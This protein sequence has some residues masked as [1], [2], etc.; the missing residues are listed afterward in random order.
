G[1]LIIALGLMVDDAIII[2]EM[3]ARK[4]EEGYDRFRASTFA[5]SAT[6]MPML[7]GTLITA[8]GFLPIGIASS[9]VGE[10][11]FAIFG[12]TTAAIEIGRAS[13]RERGESWRGEVSSEET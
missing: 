7:T 12:V 6:A 13:C 3:T 1:S 4:L 10:Y 11:A 8:A 5:Y 9:G 2:I